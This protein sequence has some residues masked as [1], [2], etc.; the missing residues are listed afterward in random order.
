MAV[1]WFVAFPPEPAPD[2]SGP[3]RIPKRKKKPGKKTTNNRNA[4]KLAGIT[5]I[6]LDVFY[7]VR[8]APSAWRWE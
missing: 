5:R 1:D 7:E 4:G 2:A 8:R 6:P 3:R